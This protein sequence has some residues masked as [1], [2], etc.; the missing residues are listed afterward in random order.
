MCQRTLTTCNKC[1]ILVG[2]CG[3]WGSCACGGA[4]GKWKSFAPLSQ[5]DSEPKSALRNSALEKGAWG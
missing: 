3:S 4:G 1:P 5:F 2:G